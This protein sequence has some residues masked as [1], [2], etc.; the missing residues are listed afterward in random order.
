MEPLNLQ[1]PQLPSSPNYAFAAPR[2]LNLDAGI[3]SPE[4][5]LGE[6]QLAKRAVAYIQN[7]PRVSTLK[8]DWENLHF[9]F[10]QRTPV[11]RFPDQ[12]EVKVISLSDGRSS[13]LMLS[14]AHYGSYDFGVN[15]R[16]LIRWLKGIK[17]EDQEE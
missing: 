14:R 3:E 13:L 4:F 8:E 7:Q 10:I 11:L 6:T 16:R 1:N 17:I 5:Q 9:M 2:N 12:I 15:K